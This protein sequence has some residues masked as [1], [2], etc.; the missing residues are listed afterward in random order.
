MTDEQSGDEE[1]DQILDELE[2]AG[3]VEQYT[4]TDGQPAM[5][6][7]PSGVQVA[8]QLAMV[9]EDDAASMMAGLLGDER[10]GNDDDEA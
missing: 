4:D 7:T 2:A 3:Y 6:M 10:E 8:H 1:F 5:R 9:A